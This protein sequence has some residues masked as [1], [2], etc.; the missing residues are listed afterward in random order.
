[1]GSTSILQIRWRS[2]L[3]KHWFWWTHWLLIHI[4][5]VETYWPFPR[6][7][8][9]V[10]FLLQSI[11]TRINLQSRFWQLFLVLKKILTLFVNPMKEQVNR[12]YEEG[13]SEDENTESLSEVRRVCILPFCI[14]PVPGRQKWRSCCCNASTKE[15][16]FRTGG[17]NY[18]P[19]YF[20][21]TVMNKQVAMGD[22]EGSQKEE[23]TSKVTEEQPA[24]W[25][26]YQYHQIQDFAINWFPL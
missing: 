2:L 1:M 10:G 4:L 13:S 23:K 11:S 16:I 3:I 26:G 24:P 5:H 19:F 8:Q 14:L 20:F 25:P 17:C 22:S 15:P 12:A 7:A 9:F 21:Y 6:K 18:L